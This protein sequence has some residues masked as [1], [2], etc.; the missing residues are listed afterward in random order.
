MAGA[1]LR[2]LGGPLT[3]TICVS[4]FTVAMLSSEHISYIYHLKWEATVVAPSTTAPSH[5][6]SPVANFSLWLLGQISTES[7][8][9]KQN[10]RTLD[11][12]LCTCKLRKCQG[13]IIS[14]L[15]RLHFSHLAQE[16]V[17][18]LILHSQH[19]SREGH[20]SERTQTPQRQPRNED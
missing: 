6:L 2:E 4:N 11:C 9:R 16:N 14:N 19:P 20:P 12:A 10:S 17:F 15:L 3:Q 8:R 18:P 5:L 13:L 1:A 7:S